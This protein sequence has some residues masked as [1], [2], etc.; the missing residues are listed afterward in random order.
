MNPVGKG[1]GSNFA[2]LQLL[3]Q[4]F[5]SAAADIQAG[6]LGQDDFSIA[7]D[8]WQYFLDFV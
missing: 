8:A 1:V 7:A 4:V 2:S 3:Q 5:E 6:S